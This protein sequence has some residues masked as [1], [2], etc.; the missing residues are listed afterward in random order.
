MWYVGRLYVGVQPGTNTLHI[1]KKQTRRRGGKCSNWLAGCDNRGRRRTKSLF[2][3]RPAW[4]GCG[5]SGC[6]LRLGEPGKVMWFYRFPML[7][8]VHNM[9]VGSVNLNKYCINNTIHTCAQVE[10]RLVLPASIQ[11]TCF[12]FSSKN[13]EC[14]LGRN[15]LV[16]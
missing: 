16:A 11:P 2:V 8:Q 4:L 3:A 10:I 12:S 6:R 5:Y 14:A 13:P 1:L 9:H 15:Y 7:P